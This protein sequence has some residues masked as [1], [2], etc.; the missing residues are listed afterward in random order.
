MPASDETTIIRPDVAALGGVATV[1]SQYVDASELSLI[2]TLSVAAIQKAAVFNSFRSISE[3]TGGHVKVLPDYS[4]MPA[5][6]DSEN[7]PIFLYRIVEG[8]DEH[9]DVEKIL[10]DF[11]TLNYGQISSAIWFLKKA[12]QLNSQEL[13]V[14]ELEDEYLLS[15]PAFLEELERGYNDKEVVRVLSQPE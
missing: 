11:P 13:D 10:A 9:L 15:N 4:Y 12:S 3:V 5:L 6:I 14:E 1:Q 2:T 8:I 7:N